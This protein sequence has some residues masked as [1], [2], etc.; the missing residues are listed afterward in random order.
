LKLTDLVKQK[1]RLKHYSGKTEKAYLSWIEKFLSFHDGKN[2]K[3]L[4]KA[5]IEAFFT[6]L[7]VNE[8]VSASTQSQAFSALRFLY[9]TVLNLNVLEEAET[10]PL[11]RA[12]RLPIVLTFEETMQIIDAASGIFQLMI[13]LLYGSGLSGIECV[14]MRIQDVDFVMNQVMVRDA[15]GAI[16][17]VTILPQSIKDGIQKHLIDVKQLH[18]KDISKGF[19][20]TYLPKGEQRIYKAV[21]SQWQWQYLFPSKMLSTDPHSSLRTRPHVHPDSLNK[22]VKKAAKTAGIKQTISTHVFRHSFAVHLLEDGYDVRTVQKLLGHKDVSTT[23]I[24][25][26]L[27]NKKKLTVRSPLDRKIVR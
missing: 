24:Y 20:S 4:G 6:D 8:K 12:K 19:G 11:Q 22:A 13:K 16:D 25:T 23:M 2:P 27:V 10:K 15:N 18:A 1:I 26:Q 3:D 7:S 14:R 21:S 5:E 17:R 9:S